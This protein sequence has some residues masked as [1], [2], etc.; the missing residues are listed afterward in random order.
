MDG[1]S[2]GWELS[3]RPPG[4]LPPWRMAA[5]VSG[6]AD[7]RLD[8]PELFIDAVPGPTAKPT[9]TTKI[10]QSIEFKSI[11]SKSFQSNYIRSNQPD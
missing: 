7:T 3:G 8:P 6:D 9:T 10:H 11:N 2:P 5:D 4:G 1:C